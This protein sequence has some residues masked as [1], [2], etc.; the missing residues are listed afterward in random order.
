[1]SRAVVDSASVR[2]VFWGDQIGSNPTDRRK[3]G[4]K[5]HALSDGQGIPFGVRLTGANRHEVTQVLPLVDDIPPVGGKARRSRR[6]PE[7]LQGD[8]GYASDPHR[9]GLRRRGITPMIARR[10]TEHGSGLGLTRWVIERTWSWRHP[11]RRLRVRRERRADIHLAFMKPACG[12]I[13]SRFIENGFCQTV[14]TG[15]RTGVR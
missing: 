10:H 9:A 5:H 3:S 8:R 11:F 15:A 12:V 7:T 1:M 6:R 14:L 2:A 13:C 4:S